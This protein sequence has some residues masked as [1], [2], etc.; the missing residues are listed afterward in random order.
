MIEREREEFA[1]RHPRSRELHERA[2]GALLA[3][4][5]MSWMT[6]WPGGHPVYLD[7]AEGA[8]LGTSSSGCT[9][10]I[11]SA[12][13]CCHTVSSIAATVTRK[14]IVAIT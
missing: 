10:A 2:A 14:I 13:R 4:V 3:G 9:A 12:R 8:R 7:Y 11:F 1:R 5:P 6:M